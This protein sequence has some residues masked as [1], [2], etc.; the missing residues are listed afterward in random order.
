MNSRKNYAVII[1]CTVTICFISTMLSTMLILNYYSHVQFQILSGACRVLTEENVLDSNTLMKVIKENREQIILEDNG[2][3]LGKYGYESVDFMDGRWE[4]G[5][6][7][8]AAC[9]GIGILIF[10]L[11]VLYWHKRER[12]HIKT[13]TDYLEKVN[14]GGQ[15]LLYAVQ[16]NEHSRLQ[17]E[18]YKTVTALYQT[19]DAA[20]AAKKNFADNLYNIA[21]QLKTPITAISLLAQMMEEQYVSKYAEQIRKQVGR[22]EHLEEAL[23]LLSRI[24]ADALILN[25][26]KTDVFTVLTL[27]ADNLRELLLHSDITAD[28]PDMGE[29][30][31]EAD[32]EWTMEAIMNLM[33]NCMEHSPAAS[34][35]HC[36]YGRCPMYTQVRI[37]DEGKGFDEEDIPH[38]FERFYRGKNAVNGGI[39]IGLSLAKALIEM[40][41]G[42]ISAG[43][44]PEGGAYFEIRIY[45]H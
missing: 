13:L 16:E 34:E 25:R 30:E 28:I 35:I 11:T 33:K 42:F 9:F 20:V 6:L 43:N 10:L 44:L 27:A 4:Y 19:R 5:Y 40:Q 21:H 38:L 24:D 7:I 26:T 18:I 15:G 29:V 39:G 41:N 14:M 36:A 22:L 1:L 12:K 3:F 17:D 23:L 37:W 32:M 31:I 8:A 2:Q 45:S